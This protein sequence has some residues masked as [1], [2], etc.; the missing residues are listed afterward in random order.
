MLRAL[1]CC[2]R[3]GSLTDGDTCMVESVSV[4]QEPEPYKSAIESRF[5]QCFDLYL[6]GGKGR[7]QCATATKP[8]HCR[9][10]TALSAQPIVLMKSILDTMEKLLSS[11]FQSGFLDGEMTP[12]CQLPVGLPNAPKN[13]ASRL[14]CRAS[15]WGLVRADTLSAYLIGSVSRP[16]VQRDQKQQIRASLRSS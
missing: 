7:S 5:V 12:P 8:K 11:L 16:Q 6:R 1:L 13:S 9:M 4:S 2:A 3:P 15:A 10:C 14:C